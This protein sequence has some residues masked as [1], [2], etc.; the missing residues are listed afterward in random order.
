MAVRMFRCSEHGPQPTR[1]VGRDGIPRCPE[2]GLRMEAD[3]WGTDG[4]QGDPR[5][6]KPPQGEVRPL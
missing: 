6:R 3:A 5:V 2:C 4:P 1:I